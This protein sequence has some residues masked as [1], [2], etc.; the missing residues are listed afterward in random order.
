M[1]DVL[2][3]G[4]SVDG[5]DKPLTLKPVPETLAAEIVTLAVPEFVRVMDTDPLVPTRRLPKLTLAG[6]DTRA[7]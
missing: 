7:P 1:K 4:T 5:V 6:L 2:C 3:P